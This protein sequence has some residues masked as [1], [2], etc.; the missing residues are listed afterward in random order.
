[1]KVFLT[2]YASYN[3]DRQF[4]F[5]HWVDLSDYSDE[6]EL[7]EYITE[8]FK[9]ADEESPLFGGAKREEYMFTD[10]EG[11][12]ESLYSES[13]GKKQFETLY[14]LSNFL[15]KR[16][17]VTDTDDLSKEDWIS[18]SNEY[19]STRI[20]EIDEY[21]INEMFST[22]WDA[23]NSLNSGFSTMQD[24]MWMDGYGNYSSGDKYDA[25]NELDTKDILNR[26]INEIN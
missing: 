9:K 14:A 16:F 20:I 25:Y 21:T 2:D 26:I 15:E 23:V 19:G 6:E 7:F 3:E 22:P 4:E 17:N 24:Y 1:M 5:G 12:P 8:H 11:F 10:Y 13:M 18:L